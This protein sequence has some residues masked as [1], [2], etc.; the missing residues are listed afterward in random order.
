MYRCLFFGT[1]AV[2]LPSLRL[3]TECLRRGDPLVQ[4]LAVVTPL[5]S[6]KSLKEPLSAVPRFAQQEQ[7]ETWFVPDELA[8]RRRFWA[9]NSAALL[10]RFDI[11]LVVSFGQRIPAT[12]LSSLPEGCINM[13][14]SLLPR[15]RGAAPIRW[16]LLQGEQTTGVSVLQMTAGKFDSGPILAQ[17]ARPIPAG[18]SY[19]ELAATL[20]DTGAELLVQTLRQLPAARLQATSQ[21]DTLATPA[22][23][24]SGALALIDW[25]HWTAAQL[26][27]RQLALGDAFPLYTFQGERRLIIV[28]C[29]PVESQP[30]LDAVHQRPG[31]L[32]YQ[33]HSLF[34][35]CAQGTVAAV[36]ALHFQSAKK[37][38]SAPEFI[39]GFLKPLRQ[40]AIYLNSP[41]SGHPP[42]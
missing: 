4:D 12:V 20:A 11:G 19:P 37:V 10:S 23:K 1:D 9:D 28:K 35:V 38:L 16:T 17:A 6:R 18:T 24:I 13:H 33:G 31:T 30:G 27:Q 25:E 22:P 5:Q 8:A 26:W 41:T 39:N 42:A 32:C 29:H 2:A 7:L 21:D 36:T 40:T 3:L 15:H 34:V 14:P